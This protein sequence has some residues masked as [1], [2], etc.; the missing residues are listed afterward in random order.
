MDRRHRAP[1]FI[2]YLPV[3]ETERN[4][5]T[6]GYTPIGEVSEWLM[7]PFSKNGR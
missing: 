5:E 6:T 2:V 1:S 3:L 7:V 4:P